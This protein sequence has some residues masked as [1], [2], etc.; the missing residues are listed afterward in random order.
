MSSRASARY[1]GRQRQDA[2]LALDGLDERAPRPGRR[3]ANAASSASVSPN[4]TNSTPP[5]S[6][7]NGSRYA[8]L[9]VSASAPIERPWNEPS[10]ARIARCGRVRRASLNAA[11]LASVPEL[12]RKTREPAGAP[13]EREQPLRERDLRRAGEE[14]G[15]VP[16]R[17]QLGADRGRERRVRVPER[18]DRDAAEQVEVAVAVGVPDVRAL[19]ADQHALR[20]P[21]RV[22][23]GVRVAVGPLGDRAVD[24]G[25]GQARVDG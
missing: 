8:A 22:H 18:V 5:G 11:S 25:H 3:R 14:V 9:W 24:G 17:A 23:D 19:A 1:P 13:D 21:E 2:G 16:E 15:D 12:V 20:R 7:S 10:S 4:G 6:G